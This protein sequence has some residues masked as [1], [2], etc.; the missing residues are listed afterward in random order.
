MKHHLI[1]LLLLIS[2][3]VY[4]DDC[5]QSSAKEAKDLAETFLGPSCITN[6][7][8]DKIKESL[9]IKKL[10]KKFCQKCKNHLDPL[11]PASQMNSS[12]NKNSFAIATIGELQKNLTATLIDLMQMRSSFNL[13]FDPTAAAS[14]C[15]FKKMRMPSCL[16][17][18]SDEISLIEKHL[19]SL[20][21]AMPHEMA[22]ILKSNPPSNEKNSLL[23]RA[24]NSCQISDNEMLFS[25]MRYTEELLTPSLISELKK[26]NFRDDKSVLENIDTLDNSSTMSRTLTILQQHPLLRSL[27]ND[28][29]SFKQ[30]IHSASEN[31]SKEDI[32][33]SL[34][35]KDASS[36]FARS[37]ANSCENAF[38]K[39]NA[40]LEQIYC[41][42]DKILFSDSPDAFNMVDNVEISFLS[43]EELDGKVKSF[44][45]VYNRQDIPK[46][47]FSSI[48]TD[49]NKDMDIELRRQ[50][51]NKFKTAAYE[52]TIGLDQAAICDLM[53]KSPEELQKHCS[54]DPTPYHCTMLKYLK[55][56]RDPKDPS[57][58]LANSSD[59]S[60]NKILRSMIEGVIVTG[61]DKEVLV[62]AGIL[63]GGSPR[64]IIPEREPS[65]FSKVTN[66]PTFKP[67]PSPQ[68]RTALAP[69]ARNNQAQYESQGYGAD[70]NAQTGA[71][72][73][74]DSGPSPGSLSSG[75]PVSSALPEADQAELMRRLMN[76]TKK[77]SKGRTTNKPLSKK[78]VQQIV[79]NYLDDKEQQT[80][81]S[82]PAT[83]RNDM[84]DEFY[85]SIKHPQTGTQFAQG[86]AKL[87]PVGKS[88]FGSTNE[89]LI[90]ANEY[91][92]QNGMG[93]SPS[94]SA[95]PSAS[96]GQGQKGTDPTKEIVIKDAKVTDLKQLQE[97]LV[98][99][100]Q[101]FAGLKAGENF[102]LKLNNVEVKVVYNSI[103][104]IYEVQ[105]S[106]KSLTKDHLSMIQKY[107]NQNFLRSGG[108]LPA[109]QGLLKQ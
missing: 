48:N 59:E 56:S 47:T 28:T 33:N 45:S 98:A 107:L 50:N 62:A 69:Q 44:C 109:L 35:S 4:A 39:T 85:E 80:G 57:H 86:G 94:P 7:D 95:D 106:D 97:V 40:H 41:S 103:S 37:I 11:I 20:K 43:L 79:N 101:Q 2:C 90:K 68:N 14:A 36:A 99:H 105:S 51:A 91:R 71:M 1:V 13:Q 31:A 26:I 29:K 87:D 27:I 12:Q 9:S 93:V 34:Y 70:F 30:F 74:A 84:V 75:L 21:L 19:N 3:C 77:T 55:Q 16:K 76:A 42:K 78:D 46:L 92:A 17:P 66:D 18:K 58:K 5:D 49:I 108:R 83:V 61:E 89:A 72:A 102:V 25:R 60:I 104:E 65:Y 81:E 100:S 64:A 88:G 15:S 73:G 63:P 8:N 10:T 82:Y 32:L 23:Q 53:N 6:M 38:T 67:S 54:I 52:R 96:N 24:T 22:N